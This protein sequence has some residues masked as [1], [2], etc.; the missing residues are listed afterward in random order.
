MRTLCRLLALLALLAA[1]LVHAEDRFVVGATVRQ[2]DPVEGD[3]VSFGGD[4]EIAAVVGGDAVAAGGNVRIRDVVQRDVYAGGGNVVLEGVVGRHVRLAGGNLDIR[5]TARIGGRLGLAGGTVSVRGPVGGS[6]EAAASDVT[7]DSEVG[8]DVRIAA[9]SVHLGPNARIGGRLLH[10]G[11]V[12]VQRD[13]AAVVA[14]G[15][16]KQNPSRAS[17]RHAASS[18]SGGWQWSMGLVILAA[19]LAAAFPALATRMGAGVRAKPGLAFGWGFVVLAFVPVAALILGI[20]I[21]G[22]PV[23]ILLVLAY[24]LALIL[25]WA[26][27]GVLLGDAALAK[28]RGADASRAAWRAG[29]AAAAAFALALLGR[30]P[31]VGWLFGLAAVLFGIGAIAVLLS[32][33]PWRQPAAA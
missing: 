4:V 30:V 18:F 9:G 24:I 21:V 10:H 27:A 29:A 2:S 14:G 31:I 33:R 3:F 6:I 17:R 8:G 20:T 25:G 13:P 1:S 11:W 32:E 28:F 7:I 5:P 19:A 12:D 22:I 23:A 26:A 15:V 16:E